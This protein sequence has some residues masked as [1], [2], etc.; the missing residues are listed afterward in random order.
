MRYVPPKSKC[1]QELHGDISQKTTFLIVT[2]V[3]TSTL[4]LR[5]LC[6]GISCVLPEP[7]LS[8]VGALEM[9]ARELA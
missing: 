8:C 2:A 1:L 6:F 9:R 7:S 5:I 4:T 3:K